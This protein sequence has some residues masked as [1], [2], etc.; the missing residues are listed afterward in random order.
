MGMTVESTPS[1]PGAPVA[2]KKVNFANLGVGAAMNMFEVTTLGQPFEV[3]K[4]HLAANRQDNMATAFK[5]IY[6]RGG[7]TGFYQG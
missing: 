2:K 6:Q 1:L 5:K 4:T 7:I 3:I